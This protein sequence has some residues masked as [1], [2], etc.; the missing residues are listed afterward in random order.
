MRSGT[1]RAYLLFKYAIYLFMVF[2]TLFPLYWI[3]ANSVRSSAEMLSSRLS[4]FPRQFTIANYAEAFGSQQLFISFRNS[5]IVTGCTVVISVLVGLCMA[6]VFTRYRFRGLPVIRTTIIVTQFIPVVVF[7]I[8][9]YL[10]MS[11][12]HLLNTHLSIIIAYLSLSIPIGT[13]LLSSYLTDVSVDIE[14]AAKIDGCNTWQLFTR[15]IMPLIVPGLL[16]TA[17]IMFVILWQEFLIAVSFISN[18]QLNTVPLFLTR[19]Q[20]MY[21]TNWGGIMAASVIISVPGLFL[22]G[23]TRKFFINNLIG[24]VKG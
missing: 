1:G 14:E 19:Y 22:F 7:I 18:E 24:G 11:E 17:I 8:P 13:I 3:V 20:G 4:W 2:F 23:L 6:Y 15:I 9:L 5:L 21:G 12:L 16:S 10:L